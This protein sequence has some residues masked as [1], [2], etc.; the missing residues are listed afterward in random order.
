MKRKNTP[1]EIK[2]LFKNLHGLAQA[3]YLVSVQLTAVFIEVKHVLFSFF[4]QMLA[5]PPSPLA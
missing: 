3:K 5:P 4:P 2:L 1:N